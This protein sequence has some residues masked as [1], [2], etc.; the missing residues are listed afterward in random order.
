[1]TFEDEN[2]IVFQNRF[3]RIKDNII[4]FEGCNLL[5]L[6]QDK[7]KANVFF[8]Y[9]HWDSERALNLYRQSSFFKEVWSET[10]KLF[11]EKPEAWSVDKIV[12]LNQSL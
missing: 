1:M 8:T 6:Y 7:N 11:K 10:K 9:S 2:I 5:E 12:S 4:N 3:D